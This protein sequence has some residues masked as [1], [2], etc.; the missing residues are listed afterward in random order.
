MYTGTII[1]RM[2]L[3]QIAIEKSIVNN[4]LYCRSEKNNVILHIGSLSINK[5]CIKT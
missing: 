2:L 3:W 1:I 4:K 5:F